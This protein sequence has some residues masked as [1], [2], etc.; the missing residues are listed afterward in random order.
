MIVKT[1]ILFFSLL[2]LMG[3][4]LSFLCAV[5]LLGLT[6]LRA[7]RLSGGN[8]FSLIFLILKRETYRSA[9]KLFLLI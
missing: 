7:T 9:H 1:G 4:N 6:N 5:L 2:F 3:I 8:M